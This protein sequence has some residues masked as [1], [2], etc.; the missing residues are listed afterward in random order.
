[1]LLFLINCRNFHYSF[2]I[3]QFMKRMIWLIIFFLAFSFINAQITDSIIDIRNGQIYKIVKIGQQWWMREN[4]N[5]GYMI[6]STHN[7]SDNKIIEKYCYDNSDSLC[8]IYGGLYLWDEMMDYCP[9]YIMNTGVIRGI[10]PVGWYL[11]TDSNWTKFIDTLGGESIAGGK[12]KE[13]GTAHWSL[14]NT[15]ATNESGFTA[16]PGGI[17]RMDGS[18][19][20]RSYFTIFWS[21]TEKGNWAWYRVLHYDLS[22]VSRISYYKDNGFSVRCLKDPDTFSF[23]TLA[24]KYFNRIS[25]FNFFDGRTADTLIIVNSSPWQIINFSSITTNTDQYKVDKSSYILTP[26]NCL[27]LIVTFIPSIKGIYLRDTLNIKC[28]DPYIQNL[29]VPL[30]GYTPETDSIIDTRDG[31][32]YKVVKIGKQWWMQ[33][34]LR[35][36]TYSDGTPLVNGTMA[37]DIFENDS[38]KY[39]FWYNDDSSNFADTYGLLYT[40]AAVMDES[41]SCDS[42][43]IQGICPNGWHVPSCAE[44][45]ELIDTLGGWDVAGGKLKVPGELY[46]NSPNTGA[47]NSSGFSALPG[48]TRSSYGDYHNINN[49]AAFWSSSEVSSMY[50][51]IWTLSNS[52]SQANKVSGA[53]SIGCSVRCIMGSEDTAIIKIPSVTTLKPYKITDK[54]VIVGGNVTDNSGT[55]V[56][57]SGIYW[58]I[59]TNP[60]IEG[61]K[62]V[63]GNGMGRFT[64]T[65][66]NL[67]ANTTYY[68]QAFAANCIGEAYGEVISFK[69]SEPYSNDSGTFIDPRDNQEYNWIKIGNQI[70]MAENLNATCYFDGKPLV[71]GTGISDIGNK[72]SVK[73]YFWYN[74]DSLEYADTYGALYTWSASMN[75]E[76]S[77]DFNPSCIQG[78][79][80]DGWH[81]PSD[82]EWKEL[83]MY[84]GLSQVEA[85]WTGLRGHDSGGKLKEAGTVYWESPN[86]GATNSTGFTA[87]PGGYRFQDG[88]FSQ[89]GK[90]ADFWSS[91]EAD[92]NFAWYRKLLY[93]VSSVSRSNHSK[94]CGCSVRCIKNNDSLSNSLIKYITQ[95]NQF[96]IYPNPFNETTTIQFPNPTSE[97]YKFILTDISGKRLRELNNITSSEIILD[98]RKL[99]AGLYLIELRGPNI[100]RGKIIIE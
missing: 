43:C 37:N 66:S 88:N 46:W 79:C 27:Y 53:K 9:T 73:Y 47:I 21:S 17:R 8:S 28:D 86:E 51:W 18:F 77:S 76:A 30:N 50:A 61:E 41:I 42:V 35:A 54:T 64:T 3:Q 68:V 71:N 32:L 83:E 33:E 26:G 94:T 34:N 75:G 84:L 90:I 38:T 97:S 87:L 6:D 16:L 92:I 15:G 1:M 96:N 14:P 55:R 62:L 36:V 29:S 19:D 2:E 82:N 22:E 99:P 52:N 100:Y 24:D 72:D 44:W 78:I 95:D 57:K 45:Q 31:Q 81:L 7:S 39:Y 5:I 65:L 60:N 98:R 25:K 58:G 63:F 67:S 49:E 93:T 12:L 23:V 13:A 11:P 69:T 20:H 4:L 59:T 85:G 56:T 91:T 74:D 48:G 40:W 70:W 10:C 89:I 80:P